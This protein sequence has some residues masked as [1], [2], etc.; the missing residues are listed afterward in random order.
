MVDQT[1]NF[2]NP[3]VRVHL[4]QNSHDL[5]GLTEEVIR[6]EHGVLALRCLSHIKDMI[7]LIDSEISSDTPRSAESSTG[8]H[9]DELPPVNETQQIEGGIEYD[10]A[11][12]EEDSGRGGRQ[13][14]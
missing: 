11:Q 7:G 5:I 1:V 14:L 13:C 8:D 10:G 6:W 4:Q 3:P 2:I 9:G 12:S